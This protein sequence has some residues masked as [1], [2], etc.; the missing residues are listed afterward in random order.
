MRVVA[1]R[2]ADVLVRDDEVD[3]RPH[4]GLAGRV[5]AG[6][7]LLELLAPL[8]REVAVQVEPFGVAS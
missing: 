2:G 8:G 1:D 5:G 6:A 4:L 7:D 3:H